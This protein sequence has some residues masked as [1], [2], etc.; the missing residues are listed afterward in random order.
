[1]RNEEVFHTL[2]EERN[3]PDTINRRT[4]NWIG[5]TLQSICLLK[6]VTERKIEGMGRRGRRHTQLLDDLTEKTGYQRYKEGALCHTL[7]KVTLEE[8]MN[9]L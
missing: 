7:C 4:A 1:M 2:K 5:H 8:V 6:H 9:L 3:I